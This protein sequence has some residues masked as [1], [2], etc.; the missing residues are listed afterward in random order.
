[1]SYKAV[2]KRN[3]QIQKRQGE[4]PVEEEPD[5]EVE[6]PERAKKYGNGK[7]KKEVKEQKVYVEEEVD[8]TAAKK[9]KR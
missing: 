6:V 7:A 9:F 4:E 3:K 5:G 2:M 1:M 8:K